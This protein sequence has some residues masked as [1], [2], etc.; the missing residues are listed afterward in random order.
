[1]AMGGEN[2]ASEADLGVKETRKLLFNG[3]SVVHE[4]GQRHI[5]KTYEPPRTMVIVLGG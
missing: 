3:V 4:P 2:N 1:M 5:R